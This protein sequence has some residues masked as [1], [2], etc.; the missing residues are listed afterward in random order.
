[1]FLILV[2][3]HNNL[4]NNILLQ[5]ILFSNLLGSSLASI[6]GKIDNRYAS[7][8][9][10]PLLLYLFENISFSSIKSMG[11]RK[12]KKNTLFILKNFISIVLV[13]LF[14]I[15]GFVI[16]FNWKY[17]SHYITY[18][19]MSPY[20]IEDVKNMELY[21]DYIFIT[22]SRIAHVNIANPYFRLSREIETD[23]V[24]SI[25]EVVPWTDYFMT[26]QLKETDSDTISYIEYTSF[27]F[28]ID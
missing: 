14:M 27:N 12:L 13:I 15:T 18:C 26:R 17:N 20:W 1:M 25:R 8:V 9:L 4:K 22:T 6:Q 23:K 7:V 16:H 21:K 3:N 28:K 19:S 24:Y 11:A 10:F 5:I 2:F